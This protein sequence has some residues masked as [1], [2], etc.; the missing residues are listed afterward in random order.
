[1][2]FNLVSLKI[3]I[4]MKKFSII[5]LSLVFLSSCGGDSDSPAPVEIMVSDFTATVSENPTS[6]DLIG[7]VSA[8][9]TRGALEFEL[10]S[11]NPVGALAINSSSGQIT[12]SN[13]ALFDY[14]STTSITAIVSVSVEEESKTANITINISDVME[15]PRDGLLAEYLFSGNANDTGENGYDPETVTATLISDRNGLTNSA[16]H[17]DGNQYISVS[18]FS[19]L[20]PNTVSISLWFKSNSAIATQRLVFVGSAKV[21]RQNYSLNYNVNENKKADFRYEPEPPTGGAVVQSATEVDDNVWHHL[22]GIRD[23][24]A[25]TL[26]IYV[27]GSLES[28]VGYIEDP[29]MADSPLNFGRAFNNQ[30]F[31]GDLDDIRI[32]DKALSEDEVGL[33]F[34]EE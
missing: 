28:T 21:G 13:A 34:N 25:K 11:M 20:S 5:V 6:G 4:K 30:Y 16:Y 3:N 7:T 26:K 24:D 23:H 31:T 12:V 29:I 2:E 1:M 9:T 22:V 10:L 19:E 32:Y 27:D 33:L 17:F 8:T 15:A 18:N 14:E